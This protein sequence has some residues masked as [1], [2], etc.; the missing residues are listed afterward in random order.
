[1][2]EDTGKK[3]KKKK[4]KAGEPERDQMDVDPIPPADGDEEEWDG[5][6]EMRKRVLNKY[7]DEVYKLDFNDMVPRLHH[8]RNRLMLTLNVQAGG[9]PTRFNYAPVP[10]ASFSLTSAEILMATDKEL[11]NY[12]GL[13]SLAPHKRKV[14]WDKGR[15]QKLKELKA[16]LA[17]RR[18]GYVGKVAPRDGDDKPASK[19]KKEMPSQSENGKEKETDGE[20]KKK[21]RKRNKGKGKET[22]AAASS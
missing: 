4:K 5:T 11:N 8:L 1:M 7:L 22:V 16:A 17:G 18:W 12:V 21:K 19:R 2:A 14:A 13:K 10:K 6:E 20:P 15:G 9:M 3:K